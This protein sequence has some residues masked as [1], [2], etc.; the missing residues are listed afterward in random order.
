M[1]WR[2]LQLPFLEKGVTLHFSIQVWRKFVQWFCKLCFVYNCS[3]FFNNYA[4]NI[5][6]GQLFGI[7]E[8]F[9]SQ[10]KLHKII[11]YL[12]PNATNQL[13]TKLRP[14]E[15]VTFWQSTNISFNEWEWGT[16][17]KKDVVLHLSKLEFLHTILID[18]SKQIN[19]R[20]CCSFKR[21]YVQGRV[22]L[23]V[24]F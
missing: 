18:R 14:N 1:S 17:W 4:T 8:L 13:P 11:Y 19:L 10:R 22:L 6:R 12:I 9:T 15:P 24:F 2:Q 5:V 7:R 20:Y 16:Y 3:L 21:L 23:K